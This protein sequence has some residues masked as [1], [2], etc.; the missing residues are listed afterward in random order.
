MATFAHGILLHCHFSFKFALSA[1]VF[2]FCLI[3]RFKK[4]K[5][6]TDFYNKY[7]ALDPGEEGSALVWKLPDVTRIGLLRGTAGL[8][9]AFLHPNG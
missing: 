1:V 3:E 4:W 2:A 7:C 6:N 5:K 9:S 8:M